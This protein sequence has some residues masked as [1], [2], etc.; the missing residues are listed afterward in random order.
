[1]CLSYFILS[2]LILSY[3]VCL[4]IHLSSI[5]LY[6]YPSIYISILIS[7]S[8]SLPLSPYIH[9]CTCF[10]NLCMHVAS[11]LSPL[12]YFY[13]YFYLCIHACP[14]LCLYLWLL[15]YIPMYTHMYTYICISIYLCT[16][17]LHRQLCFCA[18]VYVAARASHFKRC[19]GAT[20]FSRPCRNLPGQQE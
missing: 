16:H 1:M 20:V 12:Q 5:C 7:P 2:F 13:V 18:R 4:P 11:C 15:M 3:I 8:F 6:T 17:M 9:I 14:F 10:L 19:F